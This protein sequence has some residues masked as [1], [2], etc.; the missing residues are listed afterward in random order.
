MSILRKAWVVI[1]R[2]FTFAYEIK[3]REI[4]DFLQQR[5]DWFSCM[6]LWSRVVARINFRAHQSGL[7][8]IQET[9]RIT[10]CTSR[11][12]STDD[13]PGLI[14]LAIKFAVGCPFIRRIDRQNAE[15]TGRTGRAGILVVASLM[16]GCTIVT[17][18]V[19]IVMDKRAS[20]RR[21]EQGIIRRQSWFRESAP[22]MG[23]KLH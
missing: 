2:Y 9:L 10:C 20:A 18:A 1:Y 13:R 4:P 23:C 11:S 21:R 22:V 5:L 7:L 12:T 8:V 17:H 16:T 3:E 15:T 14:C 19:I 6:H